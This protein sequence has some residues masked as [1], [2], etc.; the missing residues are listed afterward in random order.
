MKLSL[1]T[2]SLALFSLSVLFLVLLTLFESA[3][4]GLSVTAERILSLLLLVLPAL[5]GIVFGMGSIV[6]KESPP[7]RGILG[8]TLNALFAVFHLFLLSFAG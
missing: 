6:R 8:I 3:L 2:K 7:W 5:L 4:T 1:G